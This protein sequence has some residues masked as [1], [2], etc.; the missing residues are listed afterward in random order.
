MLLRHELRNNFA[1]CSCV[2]IVDLLIHSHLTYMVCDGT[3]FD[4]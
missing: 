4:I 2:W 1:L 3:D